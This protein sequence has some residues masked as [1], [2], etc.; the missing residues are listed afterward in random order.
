MDLCDHINVTYL[1]LDTVKV[2]GP[3]SIEP[4]DFN[5][6]ISTIQDLLNCEWVSLSDCR[7]IVTNQLDRKRKDERKKSNNYFYLTSTDTISQ[8]LIK[9]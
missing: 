6:L 1:H 8:V 9:A 7:L 2:S 5:C 3:Q 4:L